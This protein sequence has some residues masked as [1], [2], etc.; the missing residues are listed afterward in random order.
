VIRHAT[1]LAKRQD[2]SPFKDLGHGTHG[3]IGPRTDWFS[4]KNVRFYRFDN[5]DGG[6]LSTCSHC[7]HPAAT[8]SGARTYFTSNLTF[9][10]GSTR[11]IHYQYPYNGIFSDLDGTLTGLGS[12]SW[13]VPTFKHLTDNGACTTV[14][15]IN[16][17]GI[18]CSNSTQIRRLSLYGANPWDKFRF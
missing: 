1:D 18:R 7:F 5:E 10:E 16:Y 4:I 14:D 13:A 12:N 3:I 17:H 2:A 8:D 9:L 6:A 15:T 11:K